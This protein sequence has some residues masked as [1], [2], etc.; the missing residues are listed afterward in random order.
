M[1][2]SPA[3][4]IRNPATPPPRATYAPQPTTAT[5][6]GFIGRP[7]SSLTDRGGNSCHDTA[8]C[9]VHDSAA[10]PGGALRDRFVRQGGVV[11]CPVD[12]QVI[13]R[14]GYR[15]LDSDTRARGRRMGRSG[16]CGQGL[17]FPDWL[18]E[19]RRRAEAARRA[20][21]RP[22]TRSASARAGWKAGRDPG[23]TRLCDRRSA[24]W[25]AIWMGRWKRSG[26][27]RLNRAPHHRRRGRAAQGW[28]VAASSTS[29][30]FWPP[31]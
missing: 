8:A 10:F 12:G 23:I 24:R 3:R 29:T 7:K 1:R 27:A 16:S 4:S 11:A 14:N 26:P 6:M 2:I 30:P 28:K 13:V 19:R 9:W 25:P 31:G 22:A 17:Y 20:R 18:L 15:H 21:R 5:Y